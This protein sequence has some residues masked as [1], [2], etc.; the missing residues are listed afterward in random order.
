MMS[1]M[2][3]LF[4]GSTT[5]KL[6]IKFLAPGEEGVR[7]EDAGGDGREEGEAGHDG[8][9]IRGGAGGRG[10]RVLQVRRRHA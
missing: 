2:E 9:G 4:C 5:S 8:G 1:G 6:E 3:Y 10:G 7:G